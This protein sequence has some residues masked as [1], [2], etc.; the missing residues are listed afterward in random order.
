M[1]TILLSSKKTKDKTFLVIVLFWSLVVFLYR[2]PDSL[3]LYRYYDTIK[4]FH[5][6]V[7][8]LMQSAHETSFD[9]I[10]LT[11]LK[12]LYDI[13]LPLSLGTA[14]YVSL[15]FIT[16]LM[17]I[18]VVIGSEGVVTIPNLLV[19]CVCLSV[20]F[21]WVICVSR[22]TA[23]FCFLYFALYKYIKK[24]YW[25]AA[26]FT[27]VSILTHVSMLIFIIIIAI[28]ILITPI[29]KKASKGR[30]VFLL[31]F[32]MVAFVGIGT[33]FSQIMDILSLTSIADTRYGTTYLGDNE[34]LTGNFLLSANLSKGERAHIAVML[35][36][37]P[38]LLFHNKKWDLFSSVLLLGEI[39]MVFFNFTQPH[40]LIRTAMFLMPFFGVLLCR[41]YAQN[42]KQ[43]QVYKLFIGLSIMCELWEFYNARPDFF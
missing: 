12:I 11:S 10:Y 15:Y 23:A 8:Q 41:C 7:S 9:F 19:A 20:P 21:S 34:S 25:Y 40:I 14:I 22:S 37:F 39:L 28:S 18:K 6:S 43:R 5:G 24:K 17:I 29:I 32:L 2:V 36:F 42:P 16:G 38:I 4:S 1:N 27:L 35:V 30:F 26:F 3:D 13:G 33:V 31:V